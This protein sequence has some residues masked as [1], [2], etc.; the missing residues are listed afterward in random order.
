MLTFI[1]GQD[2]LTIPLIVFFY[3][4]VKK[5]MITNNSVMKIQNLVMNHKTR[6]VRSNPAFYITIRM[7]DHI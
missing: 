4:V 7:F 3:L 2:P 6:P 5:L 1:S